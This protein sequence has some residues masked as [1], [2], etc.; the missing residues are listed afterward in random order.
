MNT[1]PTNRRQVRIIA[2][3]VNYQ[4]LL[5]KTEVKSLLFAQLQS[6]EVDGYLYE[7]TIGMS[8]HLA[9]YQK[10]VSAYLTKGWTL[11]RLPY[12]TQALLLM[13]AHEIISME[14]PKPV[15]IDEAVELAKL[16]GDEE[17]F[18]LINAILDRL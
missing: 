11:D 18:K 10:I 16:Y 3:H 4:H 12:C 9:D 15:V 5:L 17:D 7:L 13:A 2:L 8:Q 14:M 6:N 1:Q